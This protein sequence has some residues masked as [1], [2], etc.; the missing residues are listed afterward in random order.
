MQILSLLPFTNILQDYNNSY[1][2]EFVPYKSLSDKEKNIFDTKQVVLDF[3]KRHQYEHN[4]KVLISETIRINE[5]GETT[6]GVF[7]GDRIII[8]GYSKS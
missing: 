1:K 4:I 8:R 2:Y 7:D 5:Y 3:L 6:D